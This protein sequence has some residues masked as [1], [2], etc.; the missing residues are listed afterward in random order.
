MPSWIVTKISTILSDIHVIAADDLYK[1]GSRLAA[2][3]PSMKSP[4]L[5]TLFQ[6]YAAFH[7]MGVW[8][9]IEQR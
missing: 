9:L 2:F 1:K 7:M 3:L 8:E 6:Q 5:T 4:K